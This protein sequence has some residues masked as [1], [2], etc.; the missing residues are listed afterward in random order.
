LKIDHFIRKYGS[1]LLFAV[2]IVAF[3][4]VAF[5]QNGMKWDFVD[6]YLPA[7]YFLSEAV[8]NN[9]FPFWNPYMLYGVPF[10]ADLVSVFN[11][12]FWL[13]ANMFG[14]S[15]ITL[16]YVF[17]AYVFFAGINFRYFL[18]RFKVDESLGLSLAIAY[19]LSGF[20][21]GNAQ[22]LG[23]IAG[24]ALFPLVVAAYVQFVWQ[25]ETKSLVRMSLVFLLMVFASYPGITIILSYLLLGIFTYY[26]VLSIKRKENVKRLLVF[27]L[28]LAGI[29]LVGSSVLLLAYSQAQPYLSRYSGLTLE[30]VLRHPFTLRSFWSFLFPFSTTTDV[31]YFNTDPSMSNAYFG[32]FGFVLLVHALSGKIKQKLG[33][34]FLLFAVL[35]LF[36][37]LGNQFF[38]REFLYD[39]FPFMNM[40]KYPSIFR[41][42]S[43]FGFLTYAGLNC[44][45]NDFTSVDKKKLLAIVGLVVIFILFV[46]ARSAGKLE[47]AGLFDFNLS[48]ADR[49]ETATIN[50]AF[51][52]QGI[53]HL[54]LLG[55]FFLVLVL[56]SKQKYLPVV[57]VILFAFDGIISAQLNLHYTV[58]SN[59]DPIVFQE[60]LDSEPKGF[61]IPELHP[62]GE[63][64]DK[65]ASG[66]FTWRNNN[67]FPKRPTFD[68]L[69]SFKTDGYSRLSDD[70]PELLEMLKKQPLFFFSDDVRENAD[71]VN[72]GPKTILLE[73][74][75]LQ[76]IKGKTLQHHQSDQLEIK[77]FSPNKIVVHTKTQSEQLLVFQQNY[78]SGWKV[79]IDGKVQKIVQANYALMGTL[80]PA[81][82]HVVQFSYSN[83][84][85]IVFFVVSILVMLVLASLMIFI[86]WKE[87]SKH[88]RMI[89]LLVVGFMLLFVVFSVINRWHYHRSKSRLLP[90]IIQ[91]FEAVKNTDVTT[92]LSYASNSQVEVPN[93]DHQFYL[94]DNMNVAA[95][96]KLLAETHSQQFALS[97]VNGAISKEV[98]ALF[99]S[100]FPTVE[101]EMI[102][103]NSGFILAGKGDNAVSEFDENFE[104]GTTSLWK[105]DKN[106]I[107]IDSI[108]ADRYY[109]FMPTQKWGTE[110]KIIVDE[111][112]KDLQKITVS[113]DLRFP[114]KF[115][116]VNM[117]ISVSRGK[118]E[119]D[120][121]TRKVSDFTYGSGVW[122]RFAVIKTVDF[123][124]LSGDVIH[125]YLWNRTQARFDVDNLK[126]E[127]CN[128]NEKLFPNVPAK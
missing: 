93:V 55:C 11:P 88:R 26:L 127:M 123:D 34:V 32:L 19:M 119:L 61:P 39:Y 68:G 110:L 109:T 25:P 12:E 112:I 10:Y 28:I 2:C 122:S 43:I 81:G 105:T 29:V 126:V 64:S 4:Q 78:F 100:Y 62:I 101:K 86:H 57:F 125:I 40:F 31:V 128:G 45:L 13:V 111:A 20:T 23:F 51:I 87:Y 75:D 113:G 50:E 53:I 83:R 67:V 117:V 33:V 21:V 46:L 107:K 24:Y 59:I 106:R 17:L 66:K 90:E 116:E 48:L 71:T 115:A 27:H 91:E 76:N 30:A 120:Y 84:L 7:R 103:G 8:L 36:T 114:E 18:Q 44:K 38:L 56:G 80:I 63:N 16:Q 3:W 97:W 82:E 22:H 15:N 89:L 60:Y 47:S 52:L 65:N 54:L 58:V 41:A 104:Q 1:I 102:S 98:K 72:I 70:F 77:S 37:A 108:S 124:L 118:E 92:F 5:L 35:A 49:L 74:S 42:L 69:V 85:I 95:F 79:A 121:Y 9:V 6:A 94:D 99:T 73:S 96:G 14:Y